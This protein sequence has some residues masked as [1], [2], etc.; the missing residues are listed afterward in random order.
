MVSNVTS[1]CSRRYVK[2]SSRTAIVSSWVTLICR[3]LFFTSSVVVFL[4]PIILLIRA[5]CIVSL[6]VT[7]YLIPADFKTLNDSEWNVLTVILL[8]LPM[9]WRISSA[10]FFVKLIKRTRLSGYVSRIFLVLATKQVV[11]PVPAPALMTWAPVKTSRAFSC[12]M[13]NDL[14]MAS[15]LMASANGSSAL[16]FQIGTLVNVDIGHSSFS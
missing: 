3:K 8:V 2:Y 5:S 16:G 14:L 6:V 7:W 10:A 9:R 13:L 1:R 12:S 15:S 4:S 11:L